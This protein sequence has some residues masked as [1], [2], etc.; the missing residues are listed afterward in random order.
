MIKKIIHITFFIFCLQQITFSQ[1]INTLLSSIKSKMNKVKDYEADGLMKTK[2]VFLKLP[3]ASV[4]IYFK[5]PNKFKLK[6]EKGISF[7]PKGSVS[8]N[9]HT[10]FNEDN[11]TLINAGAD[12]VDNIKVK[13]VK[14]LPNNDN[15]D[16][17]I[18]TLYID[19]INLLVLKSR[20]TTKENGTY[21]LKMKYQKYSDY[22]LPDE[23]LF[24]FNTTD[25]KLPKGITFD[26]D[27]KAEKKTIPSSNSNQKGEV[28]IILS[29]YQ[30]N[31][32]LSDNTFK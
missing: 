29:K 7:V 13:V 4:K 26:F 28:K 12:K 11:Y 6:S 18:S 1:D 17:V 21:E 3:I 5:N 10:L 25:Y 31:K 20:T 22:G 2:V 30:I 19:P 24:S 23:I 14:M 16:W 32:N 9:L 27:D 15:G 8:L